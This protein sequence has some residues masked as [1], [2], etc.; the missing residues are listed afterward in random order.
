M[1]QRSSA[2]GNLSRRSMLISSAAAVA[3][4]AA[5]P[6]PLTADESQPEHE[7]WRKMIGQKFSVGRA[8]YANLRGR[9][10]MTLVGVE[11][12]T[13]PDPDRPEEFR[14]P[15]TLIFRPA[16]SKR[17]FESATYRVSNST[18]RDDANVSQ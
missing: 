8:A 17:P 11:Q 1:S 16:R 14:T 13:A 12:M 7:T 9:L 10:T 6:P 18:A 5:L 4:G 3:A 15:F 2:H